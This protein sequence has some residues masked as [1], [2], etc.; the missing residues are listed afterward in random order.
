MS[1]MHEI[2]IYGPIG[3]FGV[4]AEKVREMIQAGRGKRLLVKVSSP[5]GSVIEGS[6][7][8]SMLRDS[9]V[10]V[11]IEG[12]A[13]SIASLIAMAGRKISISDAGSIMIHDVWG[14]TVGNAEDHLKNAEALDKLSQTIAGVIAKRTGKSEDEIRELMK[15]ETWFTPQEAKDFGLVDEIVPVSRQ[16][17]SQLKAMQVRWGNEMRFRN[18]AAFAA[19]LEPEKKEDNMEKTT[20][21]APPTPAAGSPPPAEA[22]LLEVQAGKQEQQD[23]IRETLRQLV[24]ESLREAVAESFRDS[25]A[26]RPQYYGPVPLQIENAGR[27]R[28]RDETLDSLLAGK[29]R[30][31]R[32]DF[33]KREWDHLKQA[34]PLFN[35]QGANVDATSPSG[36]L[37][38]TLVSDV[39]ITVLQNRLAPLR[40][41]ARR[42]REGRL[43]RNSVVVPVY[44]AHG[45]S[46]SNPTN[47]E[48]AS[49]A[50]AT[51]TNY[52][53]TPAH[54]VTYMH[55]TNAEL[56][57]GWNLAWLAEGKA[58]EFA[59]SIMG[60]IVSLLNV[61]NFPSPYLKPYT[62]FTAADMKALWAAI[63]KAPE[64]Y[65]I[66]HHEYYKV[67]LPDNLMSFDIT[68][69]N[70][71]PGWDGV[72][73][74]TLWTGAGTDILGVV[75]NP[76][77]IVIAAGL[78]IELPNAPN[79]PATSIGEI[80]DL[81]MQIQFS[82]WFSPATRTV[83][84]TIEAMFGAAKGDASAVKLIKNNT[85]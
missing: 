84:Q 63:S 71:I 76:Q 23:D 69:T 36:A 5:G 18:F 16:Q 48:D 27:V 77:G 21:Q 12:G 37:T 68:E 82:T 3:E 45:T 66:L 41:F 1:D 55:M 40:A 25:A 65:A 9:D 85:T 10:D 72:F 81:G 74:Q 83:W 2:P 61:T 22:K 78:P 67:L 70:T 73:V 44:S 60:S 32:I 14:M 59:D 20:G 54:R 56:Q 8:Y 19:K 80:E 38:P 24:K 17:A 62:N 58:R 4:T 64:K 52:T 51:I 33:L 30:A 13:W 50:A 49:S 53:V 35:P 57:N 47:F 7:I 29:T 75:L 46:V 31:Q 34:F 28:A 15:E 39:V 11:M 79:T 26:G 42:L 43:G 6:A